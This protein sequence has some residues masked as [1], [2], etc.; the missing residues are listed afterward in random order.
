MRQRPYEL[1]V[2]DIFKE[3]GDYS[4]DFSEVRG[5]DHAKRALEAAAGSH[6]LL[7]LGTIG[8]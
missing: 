2:E 4:V 8:Q 1:N 7:T 5:Q 3:H 6:N